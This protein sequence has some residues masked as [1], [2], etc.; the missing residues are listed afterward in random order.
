MDELAAYERR[1]RRAGLPLLIEDYSAYEDVFT[2]AVP[3]LGLVFIGQL[4]G[5]VQLDW[6][7]WANVLAL[8]GGL[9]ILVGGVAVVNHGRGRPA[10][11]IPDR[12][13]PVEL[14][15]FLLVPALLPLVFGGQVVSA[16]VTAAGNA[17]LLALIYLVVGIGLLSI[18]RW[19]GA[20]LVSQLAASLKLLTRAVPVLLI[21]MIVMFIS[22]ECWQVFADLSTPALGG[23]IG[24]F[25]GIGSMFVATRLPAEVRELERDVGADPP[26]SGSQRFNVGFVLFVSQGLQVLVVAAL[27]GA[28][29][30]AFGALAITP[31]VV[32]IWV[33]HRPQAIAGHDALSVELLKVSSALAAFSGLYYAIAVLTDA[34]YREEFLDDLQVSLRETF[35]DRARYLEA[36][37]PA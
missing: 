2:R 18:L 4:L 32:E 14:A 26:L 19:A 35:R 7:L 21:F 6:P 1:L 13:G 24:L 15:A 30:V 12:V 28:F 33:G 31:H 34:T 10:L 9:A 22:T 36:R 3:L 29:F 37:A 20:R 23:V 25:L 8:A 5:A 16:M 17:A 27:V 11:S